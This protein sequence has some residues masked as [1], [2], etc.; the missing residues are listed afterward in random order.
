V[1]VVIAA[2]LFPGYESLNIFWKALDPAFVATNPSI[3]SDDRADS[4]RWNVVARC[5]N[6]RLGEPVPN[7]AYSKNVLLHLTSTL[8]GTVVAESPMVDRSDRPI[9][10]YPIHGY[11]DCRLFQWQGGLWATATCCD[12]SSEGN[13]ELCLL[14]LDDAYHIWKTIPLRGP[15]SAFYQKNWIPCPME[16]ELALVYSMDRSI[17]LFVK[18]QFV[19]GYEGQILSPFALER[20]ILKHVNDIRWR[21]TGN[22]R[23]SSQGVPL[24]D[25]RWMF[26]V[27]EPGYRSRFVIANDQFRPV[28]VSDFFK[29]RDRGRVEFCAGMAIHGSQIVASYS[30]HDASLELG[31]FPMESVMAT[32]RPVKE[33]ELWAP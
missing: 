17:V 8:D 23:G 15:W 22:H 26:I 9:T 27:H 33:R 13:R 4:P 29:F 3:V 31:F 16:N 24:G 2:D 5:I 12:L 28:M 7:P 30:V 6:Y 14:A 11:E 10:E 1:G 21:E 20:G 18:P 25:G 19:G 32:M